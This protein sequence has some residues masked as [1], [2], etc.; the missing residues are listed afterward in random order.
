MTSNSTNKPGNY[1]LRLRVGLA[2]VA[3]VALVGGVGGWASTSKIAGAV[4]ASG[5]VAVKAKVKQIQHP[6]GGIVGEILVENGDKVRRGDVLIRLDE[7]E[8][9]SELG[10]LKSQYNE[11][12]GRSARLVAERDSL[13][14]IQFDDGFEN[15][16]ET[17]PIASGERRLFEQNRAMRD[18]QTEQL[19]LQIEQYEEQIHGLYAVRKSNEME[20]E[21]ALADLDRMST[22]S[23]RGL[24]EKAA[25][26][27]LQRDLAGIDGSLGE[28]A[29]NIARIKGQISE[30]RLKII[31]IDRETRSTAQREIRDIEAKAAELRERI[32]AAEDRL[33][34]TAVRSPID[35]TVSELSIHTLG[36]VIA[37]GQEIM[38]VVPKGELVVEARLLPTS[39]DQVR[40]GQD[41]RLRFSAFSQRTTPEIDGTVTMVSAAT[42]KDAATGGSYY[43]SIIRI[44]DSNGDL[45]NLAL[46]P[47]MPVEVF[48]QTDERTVA[49]Y[50]AKPIIDR[51]ERAFRED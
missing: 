46:I 51:F 17:A 27:T 48:V 9:R 21:I 49:S 34:R 24:I 23:K 18:A 39:I 1:G 14:E 31:E 6:Y 41:A 15:L 36:G 25:L 2:M 19:A 33:L 20:R 50:L 4:I 16:E 26:S 32:T 44:D 11:L 47:G 29:A 40:V 7:T 12:L 30:T 35:G 45:A 42:S 8:T 10:V 5:E 22:L 37:A 43:A 28:I 13:D 3:A 38:S